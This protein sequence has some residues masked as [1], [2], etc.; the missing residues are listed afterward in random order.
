MPRKSTNPRPASGE[1]AGGQPQPEYRSLQFGPDRTVLYV[2][3]VARKLR[4]TET[5]VIGLIDEGKLRAIN[6]GC[7][8][9]GRKFYRIPVDAWN[10]YLKEN[11]L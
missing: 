2:F 4:V 7:K 6:I 9:G 8:G 11:L 1:R 3:E 5:H 10:A